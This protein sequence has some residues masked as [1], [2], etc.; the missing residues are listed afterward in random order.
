MALAPI[1]QR[2]LAGQAIGGLIG[3]LLLN[4]A[5]AWLLFPPVAT[6]PMFAR[7]NCV[8]GDTIGTSFFM[9]LITCLVLTPVVRR[10]AAP[11]LERAALPAAVRWLPANMVARGAA[12]GLVAAIVFAWPALFGLSR[13]GMIE[14]TRVEVTLFK[15]A[16]TALV[17]V[18]ITPLFG[19]RALADPAAP[20]GA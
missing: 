7:G 1:H 16:Y 18:V 12:V 11:R 17:G 8:A 6:L 15:A 2:T 13:A 9:S 10:G 3:N 4:G 5:M 20:R 14:M 19:L